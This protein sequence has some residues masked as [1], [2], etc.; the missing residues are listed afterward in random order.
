VAVTVGARAGTELETG[1]VGNSE[2]EK[3]RSTPFRLA[4]WTMAVGLALGALLAATVSAF[5]A[6]Q[7]GTASVA[8][9][10]Q[11]ASDASDLYFSLSDL[12]AEA[13]RLVLLGNGADPGTG[14]LDHAGDQIAALTAYNQRTAQADAD[15]KQLAGEDENAASVTTLTG[16]VTQ[17]HQIVDAAIALDQTAPSTLPDTMGAPSGQPAAAAIGYYARAT[18]LMQSRLLPEARTLRDETSNALSDA[19]SSAHLAGIIG[20][21]AVGAMGL[22]ALVLASRMHRRLRL[23]FRRTINPG[24]VVALLVALGLGIGSLFALL[25]TARDASA[26]GARFTDYLAVTRAR[27]ASYDVDGA[28]S[29]YLLMPDT[30]D[31]QLRKALSTANGELAGL[32]AAGTEAAARW[33]PITQPPQGD[34]PAIIG[35]SDISTALARDTGTAR[36]DEAFDFYYYDSALVKLSD[37]R[38]A[39]FDT[40]MTSARSDLSGWS[41]LPWSLVAA[42]LLALGFGVRPR[43]GEYR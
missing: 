39:A 9:H 25:G 31:Q 29:R 42:G 18:T 1:G 34:I 7:D 19:A 33:K 17:Y 14:A 35:R 24:I 15:L 3:R 10:A 20:A 5:T 38:R 26:A 43:F 8:R 2:R 13:A 6:A 4:A 21:S 40:A 36:G 23:W 37:D 27:A 30:T 32:G 12:D 28:V 22:L 16:G 11:I 41:W